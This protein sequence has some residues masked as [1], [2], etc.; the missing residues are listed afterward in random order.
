[1][2]KL[3]LTTF[4]LLCAILL[5][6]QMTQAYSI[7]FGPSLF[8]P[9]TD[10]IDYFQDA[11]ILFVNP[12]SVDGYFTAPV[13]LPQGAKVTSV[14][15]YYKDN[16]T[17]LLQFEMKRLNIYD[18]L[19]ELMFSS[20]TR[21]SSSDWRRS[22]NTEIAHPFINNSSFLYYLSVLFSEGKGRILALRA[23]KIKYEL[24]T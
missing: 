6:P 19:E 22:I 1:M 24:I 7:L 10:D 12:G 20:Y 17:E 9:R 15:V 4:G 2:K 21:G 16:S 18:N 11:T 5:F 23:V 14:I 13:F 8:S 3:S